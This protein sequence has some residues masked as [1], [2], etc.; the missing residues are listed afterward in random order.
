[1]AELRSFTR[2]EFFCALAAVAVVA[3]VPLPVGAGPE[4]ATVKAYLVDDAAWYLVGTRTGR[5][6]SSDMPGRY[7]VLS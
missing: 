2:R 7:I 4:I 3:A 1:M 5:W 6:M